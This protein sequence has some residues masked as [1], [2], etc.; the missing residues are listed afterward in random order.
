M[1]AADRRS[2]LDHASFVTAGS[3][4]A[5][6]ALVILGMALA[7]FAVPYLIFLAF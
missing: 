2:E 3:T 6:Y 1:D 5:A 4:F 7:L